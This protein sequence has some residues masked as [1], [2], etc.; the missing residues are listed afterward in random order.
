[1]KN[2]I[3]CNSKTILIW[4]ITACFIFDV[5][6]SALAASA[7]FSKPYPVQ[8]KGL[9]LGVDN[10][11]ISTEEPFISRDGRFLFFNTAASENNK[12]LHF[13]EFIQ[14]Q[15]VYRGPIGPDVNTAKYVEGNPTMDRRN[16]FLYIDTAVDRMVRSAKFSSETGQLSDIKEFQTIPNRQIDLVYQK[17]QGNMGVEI[18]AD[19]KTIYFSRAVWEMR[20]MELGRMVGSDILFLTKKNGTYLFDKI[21]V[22]N[23]MQNINTTDL[24]YAA[25]IS[26][27]GLELFFTRMELEGLKKG[28]I[29]SR[30]MHAVRTSLSEPFGH[31]VMIQTIGSSNFVEG[32]AISPDGKELYYHKYNGRKFRIFKVRRYN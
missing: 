26:A 17:F 30:I 7:I 15:W 2:F 19:G 32:P 3:N 6:Q 11:P 23:I 14:N 25:S 16:K 9:P 12:D 13:A 24:E 20:G 8:I 21:W 1:M 22:K 27:D 31:P 5:S 29:S 10:T 28:K 4:I 18:S